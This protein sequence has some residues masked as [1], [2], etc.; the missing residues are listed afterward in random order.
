MDILTAPLRNSVSANVIGVKIISGN[1]IN[2]YN[3]CLTQQHVGM[4][5]S[6]YSQIIYLFY[7]YFLFTCEENYPV[8]LLKSL[9]PA[10]VQFNATILLHIHCFD[11]YISGLM[12]ILSTHYRHYLT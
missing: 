12:S 6:L 8:M 5:F 4:S 10:S 2:K 9:I 7:S 1:V 11:N 3:S